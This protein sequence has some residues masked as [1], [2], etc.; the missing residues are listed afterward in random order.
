MTKAPPKP[1]AK[2]ELPPLPEKFFPMNETDIIPL[3]NGVRLKSN[4]VTQEGDIASRER[5]RDESYMLD[6]ALNIQVPSPNTSLEDLKEINPQLDTLL[7]GLPLLLQTA[8]VSEFYHALYQKKVNLVRMHLQD[9]H[10][11]PTRHNFFD[12][13][14]IL[15]MRSP[16]TGRKALLIQTDM[17]VVTDGT[18]G[19]RSDDWDQ[20]SRH[21]QPFTSYSWAKRTKKLHPL[22]DIYKQETSDISSEL[23]SGTLSAEDKRNKARRLRYVQRAIQSLRYRSSLVASIDPFIV[24]PT[25]V[26][27]SSS[28][29]YAPL[30]GD[31][32]VVIYGD[33]IFPAI[34]GD[35]GPNTKIG[36][37]SMLICQTIEPQSSGIKRAVSDLTVTYLVFP[38]SRNTSFG[39]PNLPAWEE[40]C[41]RLLNEIDCGGVE[42]YDWPAHL[43]K[44][45]T[46]KQTQEGSES[47]DKTKRMN[48]APQSDTSAIKLYVVEKGDSLWKIAQ[49]HKI[50]VDQIK[51][52]NS[53]TSD[54]IR[55]GQLLKIPPKP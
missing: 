17:D 28:H 32:A 50:T 21:F 27:K 18:D 29:A 9:F 14:T 6:V 15:E 20:T 3:Y 24:I 43:A 39:P 23:Q 2:P 45:N 52:L 33:Q 34:V 8:K 53:L 26:I 35:A 16:K 47:D 38:K 11:I 41:Q 7:P 46:E 25:F 36:E 49:K 37:A 54:T 10:R 4:I 44:L 42:L 48:A 31:Y 5:I 30:V 19:D 12:C 55:E 1:Q 22:Y 51:Q 13:E 40:N